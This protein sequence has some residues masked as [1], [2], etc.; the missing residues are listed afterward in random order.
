LAHAIANSLGLGVLGGY[1]SKLHEMLRC[2]L[3]KPHPVTI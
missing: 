2:H 3:K 1:G